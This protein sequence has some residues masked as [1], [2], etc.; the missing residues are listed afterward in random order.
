MGCNCKNKNVL[1]GESSSNEGKNALWV[2]II[3]HSV[4][5]LIFLLSLVFIIPIINVYLIYLLFK[6]VV[7]NKNIDTVDMLNSIIKLGK[8]LNVDEEE[9]D[10]EDEEEDYEED[11]LILTEYEDISIYD[12]NLANVK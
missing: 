12:K 4:K 5:T 10:D 7:L 11:E 9:E 6:M 3:E 8:R 1:N 2:S